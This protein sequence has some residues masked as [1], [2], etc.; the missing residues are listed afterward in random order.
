V[1]LRV[2]IV[3]L[4]LSGS[5]DERS[6]IVRRLAGA[7][8]CA[9]DV[10]LLIPGVRTSTHRDGAMV[11]R[12]FAAVPA[13]PERRHALMELLFGP[14][15]ARNSIRC[16]CTE[17]VMAGAVDVFPRPL[18]EE[19]VNVGGGRSPG[20]LEHLLAT[21]YDV[22]VLCD[23][24]AAS[25]RDAVAVLPDRT[26]VILVPMASAD[27][28]LSLTI[29][30]DVYAQ[31]DAVLV[32][33]EEERARVAG[34]A[35][36]AAS[37]VD[38]RFV[39]RVHDLVWRN[40]PLGYDDTPTIVIPRQWTPGEETD[41]LAQLAYDV[42]HA[43]DDRV[44]VRLVGPGC[45]IVPGEIQGPHAQSRLDIWRWCS[46]ALAVLDPE[47]AKLLGREALESM[48]Y[49][50]PIVV[51]AAAGATLEHARE[52]SGGLWYRTEEELLACL[53]VLLDPSVR[54]PLGDQAR[55]YASEH[56]SD[57]DRFIETVGEVLA[58]VTGRDAACDQIPSSGARNL[59]V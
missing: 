58:F 57:T 6:V 31:T 23:V 8:A 16:R 35:G 2:G 59:P 13:Q 17:Q 47:P 45:H 52:G 5:W 29:H 28:L 12:E 20:L 49:G 43:F 50:T 41:H 34:R 40:E 4:P 48:M 7:L 11:V 30:D 21:A 26:P 14:G 46:R 55:T 54:G 22:V 32:V 33:T 42:Q 24:A 25:T 15:E 19:L 18:Q 39:L 56:Y 3:S 1:T 36:A 10:E 38:I 27:P 9:A 51:P 53:E 37:A 44:R